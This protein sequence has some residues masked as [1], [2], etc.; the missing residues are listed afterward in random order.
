MSAI[1]SQLTSLTIVY[2]IVYSDAV[3]R[4]HQSSASLAFVW[5]IHRGSVNSPHKGPV[6]RKMFP[7]DDVIM[8]AVLLVNHTCEFM[9]TRAIKIYHFL[10]EG[11]FLGAIESIWCRISPP[12]LPKNILQTLSTPTLDL[13]LEV[14]AQCTGIVSK[15][16]RLF[17]CSGHRFLWY[18]IVC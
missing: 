18:F 13:T 14:L 12:K 15:A 2:S 9:W 5:G 1:A 10:W 4:N 7:F 8:A 6:T 16:N 3:Q 17:T 11:H